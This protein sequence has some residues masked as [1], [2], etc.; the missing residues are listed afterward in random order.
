MRTFVVLA[1]D[2]RRA[3]SDGTYPVLLRIIHY[4]KPAA[5]TTGVYLKKQDW[6]EKAR[7]I[8]ATYKGTD[9]VTRLNN[10]RQKKKTEAIDLITKLDEK[11]TLDGLS[12]G[13]IKD[14]I[15]RKSELDSFFKFGYELVKTMK[16]A[17][18]IGN[19]RTY[20][21][22][23][24]VLKGYVNHKDLSFRDI[25]YN[26]LVQFE[27]EHLKKGN[28]INGLSVY[29]RT[30]RSIFNRAI[31]S[32]FIGQDLYPFKTYVIKSTKTRKRAITGAAI[33]KVEDLELTPKDK[34]FH[35]RNYFLLS[36]YFMGMS[37]VDLAH[38]KLSDMIDGRIQY[39]RQKTYQPLNME[40]PASAQKI[41]DFY[42][43]SKERGDYIF[44]IITATNPEKQYNQ[45]LDARKRFNKKLKEIAK[46]CGI[47]ENLTSYV[48]RHSFATRANNLGIPVGVISGM[49]GHTDAKTTQIYLDSLPTDMMDEFHKKILE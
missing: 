22:S 23:L 20:E 28:S 26:F 49:L 13:Q 1:L 24:N 9:S 35:A 40:I 11:K 46:L 29:L 48:S 42:I 47:Q 2:T 3:K 25:N 34:F 41:L 39:E 14:M 44:P 16:E 19:A 32:G 10:Y 18:Q 36:Y 5:I 4:E 45:V 37:F 17:N 33:K 8:K 15:L 30:I 38:L 6:D 43:G 12:V 7:S 21:F 31:K 27:N